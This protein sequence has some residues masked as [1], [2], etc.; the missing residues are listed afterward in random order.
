M[1]VMMSLVVAAAVCGGHRDIVNQTVDD[2]V[3]QVNEAVEN[4]CSADCKVGGILACRKVC[5][6]GRS[7]TRVRISPSRFRF[8][9]R[10]VIKPGC[11]KAPE[12]P[13]EEPAEEAP[14]PAPEDT[15][16]AGKKVNV[17]GIL[18]RTRARSGLYP[19][20]ED[21]ELTRLAR[22]RLQMNI[23]RGHWGHPP[24]SLPA[25][26]AEGCGSSLSVKRA[27]VCYLKTRTYKRAGFAMA[28]MDDGRVWQLALFAR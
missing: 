6:D 27:H 4:A 13:A 16:D 7:V 24:I 5:R 21:P 23:D 12:E 20:T 17:F 10:C 19:L 14:A 1:N 26:C 15:G 8:F 11:D 9:Q 22:I 18:N 3:K 28:Q 2:I 25:G